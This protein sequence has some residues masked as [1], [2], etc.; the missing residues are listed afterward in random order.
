MMYN[1]NEFA[2]KYNEDT[3]MYNV[4]MPSLSLN[5]LSLSFDEM[6]KTTYK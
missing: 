5:L 6:Q 3:D 2:L 4:F 1:F